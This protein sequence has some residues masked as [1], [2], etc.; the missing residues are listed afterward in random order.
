[1][2]KSFPVSKHFNQSRK[3]LFSILVEKS[4]Q[5][6]EIVLS[7]GKKSNFYIDCKQSALLA[8]GHFLIGQLFSQL[9]YEKAPDVEAVGGLTLGADPLASAT[10]TM[11][12]IAGRKLNAFLIRKEPKG[13]GTDSYLE[14]VKHL[15]RGMPV[16]I[17]EDVITTG[18]STIKAIERAKAFELDVK[19][20]LA[21][22]DR[23]EG[24]R[25]EVEKRAPVISLFTK[26]E[27][28]N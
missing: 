21:L 4:F 11:S 18:S 27:F 23:T 28:F 19:L 13:H 24:G 12:Y 9:I 7:S 16:A 17:L 10:A 25:I 8:E 5:K 3:R 22:V 26:D 6:R 2:D 15:R 20:V 1:M 14:G